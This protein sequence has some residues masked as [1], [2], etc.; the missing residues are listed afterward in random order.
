MGRA[1]Q[2]AKDKSRSKSRGE[3]EPRAGFD[4]SSPGEVWKKSEEKGRAEEVMRKIYDFWWS[5]ADIK[6]ASLE[7]DPVFGK[8]LADALRA[9]ASPLLKVLLGF[10]EGDADEAMY[11]INMASSFSSA[12][13]GRATPERTLSTPS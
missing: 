12:C 3:Q 1:R 9:G 6:T 8:P 5:Q 7:Q 11:M 10:F 13:T 4:A 2:R